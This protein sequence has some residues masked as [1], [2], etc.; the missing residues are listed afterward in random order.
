MAIGA[1]F[2]NTEHGELKQFGERLHLDEIGLAVGV[3]AV[4]NVIVDQRALGGGHR[5]LHGLE[6]HRDVGARPAFLDHVDNMPQM[7]VRALQPLD[8]T[9]MGCMPMGLCHKH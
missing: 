3:K 9:G 1:V 7:T 4:V 8:D 5:L 2:Q 6:L